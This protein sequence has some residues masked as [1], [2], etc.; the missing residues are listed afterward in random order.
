MGTLHRLLGFGGRVTRRSAALA[1]GFLGNFRS[2]AFLGR[3]LHD[4]DRA[5]R[6]L[7][8]HGL[9]QVW[10]RAGTSD[11]FYQLNRIVRL[12]DNGQYEQAHELAS[13]MIEDSAGLA[14][15]WNQRALAHFGMGEFF[16][17]AMDCHQAMEFNAY[18]FN[19]AVGMGHSY[20]Q[21]EDMEMALDSFRRAL[22]INP[23]LEH[24]R[25]QIQKLEKA[26]G[27]DLRDD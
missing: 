8:E 23:N 26:V 22:R 7:A 5:V 9:R 10:F 20:L 1:I 14:E 13:E 11:Q 15:A 3:A 24:A 25:G 4:D 21:L 12:N 6:L 17:S 27:R 16:E 19:A 18:Q 2:N